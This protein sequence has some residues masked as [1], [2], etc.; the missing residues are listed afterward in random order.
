MC[1]TPKVK[2]LPSGTCDLDFTWYELIRDELLRRTVPE[3][4]RVL[5]VGCGAGDVLRLLSG[6]IEHGVGVDISG[7]CVTK[8]RG[9]AIEAGM[10]NLEF[11][12]AN[13]LDLPFP[14][15]AFDVVLC[16]GD[17]LSSSTVYGKQ[18][19][20]LGEMRRALAESG[21]TV[22]EG[23]NW[24]WE[25]VGSPRWTFF[26]RTADGRFLF[27]RVKRTPSGRETARTYDVAPGS[28]LHDWLV[29]QDWPISPSGHDVSLDV[30]EEDPL[31]QRWLRHRGLNK[32]QFYGAR[33]LKRMYGKAG[34]CKVEVSAY[35]QTYD[36]VN[37]AGL[38]D[39]L[40]PVMRRLAEA[41]AELTLKQRTG[42][43]PWLFLLAHR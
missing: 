7:E 11:Q 19:R 14:A 27:Q 39:E 8:A 24:E 32:Y 9:R 38:L 28:P 31:P 26:S 34:F 12:Q 17:V 10:V 20:A 43:G 22:Y 35:G 25:Y 18:D 40:R 36:I 30:V 6:R 37:N 4:A 42:S 21:V 29:G 2:V 5:D 33:S 3:G 41:E 16:L 1:E 23:M 13:V 15:A